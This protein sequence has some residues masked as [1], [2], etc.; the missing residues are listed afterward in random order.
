MMKKDSFK[1]IALVIFLL[2]ILQLLGCSSLQQTNSE[3]STLV[4]KQTNVTAEKPILA[5]KPI[6]VGEEN[7]ARVQKNKFEVVASE[8]ERNRRLWQESN[9]V[10]Y[11][12]VCQQF[13][14]GV[15]G[16]GAVVI[17][18]RDSKAILIEKAVKSDLG[19]IDGYEKFGTADKMFDYIQQELENGRQI[20]D[21]KYNKKLGYPE[22][23]GIAY[24]YNIDDYSDVKVTNFEIAK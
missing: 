11:D 20:Y 13:A 5:N 18:V 7:F 8:L 10:N 24:S 15:N 1:L 17:K 22:E 12:F 3:N 16:W 21:V 6:N 14:G 9:I 19:K 2:T 4:N 23:I